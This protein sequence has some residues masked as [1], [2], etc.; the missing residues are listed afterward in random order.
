MTSDASETFS[1]PL[2]AD[3]ESA[4]AEAVRSPHRIDRMSDPP[5][6]DSADAD[7]IANWLENQRWSL[8]SHFQP[9]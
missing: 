9:G 6:V 2:P 5:E 3:P 4:G 8:L 7:S 1:S